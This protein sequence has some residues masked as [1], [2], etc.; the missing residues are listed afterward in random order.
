MKRACVFIFSAI[1][2]VLAPNLV[3]SVPQTSLAAVRCASKKSGGSSKNLG[4]RSPGKRYGVKKVE[5]RL[6]RYSALMRVSWRPSRVSPW[7]GL[8]IN[9]CGVGGGW[10]APPAERREEAQRNLLIQ[11]GQQEGS[12]SQPS[13]PTG[14]RACSQNWLQKMCFASPERLGGGCAVGHR[15]TEARFLPMLGWEAC[16][17]KGEVWRAA[18][19]KVQLLAAKCLIISE[20]ADENISA[21]QVIK[22]MPSANRKC[23]VPQEQSFQGLELLFSAVYQLPSAS[24]QQHFCLDAFSIWSHFFHRKFPQEAGFCKSWSH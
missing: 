21:S 9:N 10:G 14:P 8:I 23:L 1:F 2:V 4:G 7:Q 12:V 3:L 13:S 24:P 17:Q 5:G 15:R 18:E 19:A 16:L 6:A 11:G 22:L 20:F